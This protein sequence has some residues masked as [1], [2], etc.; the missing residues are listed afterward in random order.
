MINSGLARCFNTLLAPC[1]RRAI[2]PTDSDEDRRYKT[3]LLAFGLFVG[4]SGCYHLSAAF[5]KNSIPLASHVL[6]TIPIWTQIVFAIFTFAYFLTVRTVNKRLVEVTFYVCLVIIIGLADLSAIIAMLPRQWPSF[7]CVIDI[8]LV[9]DMSKTLEYAM[10]G[11]VITWLVVTHV[12]DVRGWGV[13]LRV[14]LRGTDVDNALAGVPD[15]CDCAEPP[16][17]YNFNYSVASLLGALAVFLMDFIIT[18][19]FAS[20]VRVEKQKIAASIDTAQK[21]TECLVKFDLDAA[22]QIL[23]SD[24]G[25]P[26]ELYQSFAQLLANL[27][28]YRPY[29]PDA[30]MS[31]LQPEASCTPA[32]SGI[33]PGTVSGEACIVFTDIVGSTSLWANEP[34]EMARSLKM[35]NSV[36]RDAIRTHQGYEVKTIGDAFMVAFETIED[37]VKFGLAVQQNLH[38]CA[39][40]SCLF[41]Y[42]QAARDEYGVW[43]GLTVRIGV[44]AGELAVEMNP[45]TGRADYFGTTV[46]VAARTEAASAHGAVTLCEEEYNCLPLPLRGSCVAGQVSSVHLRGIPGY[47]QLVSLFPTALGQRTDGRLC[48]ES[49]AL[50]S[51]LSLRQATVGSGPPLVPTHSVGLALSVRSVRTATIASVEIACEDEWSPDTDHLWKEHMRHLLAAAERC[52]GRVVGVI[53]RATCVSWNVS[54]E[55]VRHVEN[56]M[57][58]AGLLL[59]DVI[60]GRHYALGCSSGSVAVGSIGRDGQSFVNVSGECVGVSRRLGEVARLQEYG[61]LYVNLLKKLHLPMEVAPRMKECSGWPSSEGTRYSNLDVLVFAPEDT[62]SVT[63]VHLLSN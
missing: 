4:L 46:N 44:H 16:C 38:G 3:F 22:R 26:D 58:L 28:E 41:Q 39:W 54:R 42:P 48:A 9:L 5:V 43:G 52:Q 21:V 7:V 1:L 57:T 25:M 61:C 63:R 6:E 27:D 23:Q 56:C 37:G 60:E 10:V 17:G 62:E 30:L 40:P 32:S 18:R 47:A 34:K 50:A 19:G 14:L 49:A 35:H 20:Q 45:V 11:T 29:L 53:G 13:N 36:I 51:S 15:A 12:N 59:R 2:L 33:A 24:A 31:G 8:I 55:C